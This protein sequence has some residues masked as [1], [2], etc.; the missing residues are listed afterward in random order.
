MLCIDAKANCPQ[1]ELAVILSMKSTASCV[2]N[3]PRV[4]ELIF[5]VEESPRGIDETEAAA[6]VSTNRNTDEFFCYQCVKY[7]TCAIAI[8]VLCPTSRLIFSQQEIKEKIRK[9]FA[10]RLKISYDE[11]DGNYHS[12]KAKYFSF[13]NKN[14]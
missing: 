5:V 1:K 8:N 9:K 14:H 7:C 10:D 2:D 3:T 12:D 11:I 4:K 6:D 13:A